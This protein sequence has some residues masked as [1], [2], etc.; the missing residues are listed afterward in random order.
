VGNGV[1]FDEGMLKSLGSIG[2]SIVL[3]GSLLL[4]S[5]FSVGNAQIALAPACEQCVCDGDCCVSDSGAPQ[6]KLPLTATVPLGSAD[7]LR[8]LPDQSLVFKPG[9]P[10][11]HGAAN[12]SPSKVS[13]GLSD[14]PL[15]LICC[16]FLI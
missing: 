4:S 5:V 2:I 3:V 6:G 7:E 10:S 13:D 8:S 14:L 1:L 11:S 16:S 9:F 12:S 15:F